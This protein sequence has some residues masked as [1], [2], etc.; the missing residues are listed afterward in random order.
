MLDNTLFD[1]ICMKQN[2]NSANMCLW[3]KSKIE[4]V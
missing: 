3:N 2:I 4:Q 1:V